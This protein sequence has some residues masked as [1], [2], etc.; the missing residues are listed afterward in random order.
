MS[1]LA[2]KDDS[3][4]AFINIKGHVSKR[5]KARFEKL[6]RV[7]DELGADAVVSFAIEKDVAEM[8]DKLELYLKSHSADLI[9]LKRG[10]HIDINLRTRH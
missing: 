8:C 4:T 5:T 6:M 1:N 9:A 7:V 3:D 2:R 10:E